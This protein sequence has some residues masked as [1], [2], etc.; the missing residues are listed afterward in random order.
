MTRADA[1][2]LRWWMENMNHAQLSTLW[3]FVT[4]FYMARATRL[5]RIELREK[6]R[7]AKL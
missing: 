6:E 7:L 5:W 2:Q 4:F 1:D 3:R